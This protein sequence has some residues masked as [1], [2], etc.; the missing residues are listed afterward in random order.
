MDHFDK[1][2][3]RK[4]DGRFVVQ[5]PFRENINTLGT[6]R[7]TA[8]KRFL[9]LENRFRSNPELKKKIYR[10]YGRIREPRPHEKGKY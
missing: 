8:L 2:V 5:L 3:E 9:S 10:I 6:S 4:E 7:S 1:T